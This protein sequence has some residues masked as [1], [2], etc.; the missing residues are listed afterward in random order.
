MKMMITVFTIALMALNLN[1][2]AIQHSKIADI[3]DQIAKLISSLRTETSVNYMK[4]INQV[5]GYKQGLWIESTN[6]RIWFVN[7]EK[8]LRHG[9]MTIYHT[10]GS[11]NV[12]ADYDNGFLIGRVIFYDANGGIFQTYENIE[13]NDTIVERQ[14]E[15]VEGGRI[16][17]TNEKH[18]YDYKAYVERYT[19][20][21]VLYRKGYGL[22]DGNWIF[23]LYPVG[24]WEVFYD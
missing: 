2:Q 18:R 16:Y 14:T 15:S 1:G 9:K 22:F 24:E 21:G 12:E 20:D 3:Q 10:I 13:I 17:F 6:N 8:G 23:Q 5:E 7:Y 11:K 4:H 19:S